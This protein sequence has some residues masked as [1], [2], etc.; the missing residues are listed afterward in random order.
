VITDFDLA[1]DGLYYRERDGAVWFENAGRPQLYLAS[2]D[3]MER[4]FFRRVEVA[5]P[6]TQT[7]L[8]TRIRADLECYL[9]DTSNAWLLQSDGSYLQASTLP[10]ATAGADAQAQLLET[11]AA[12]ARLPE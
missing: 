9:T 12:A 4:N 8:R 5:F 2:A 10:D 11:Y 1:S 3:W 7:R 6:V